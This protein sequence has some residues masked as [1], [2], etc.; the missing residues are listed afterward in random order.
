M[1]GELESTARTALAETGEEEWLGL[2]CGD[3]TPSGTSLSSAASP[4]DRGPSVGP[5]MPVQLFNLYYCSTS[6]TSCT[7]ACHWDH[8]TAAIGT[9]SS[10]S[11]V[12]R[13]CQWPGSGVL[14]SRR[15]GAQP[16]RA[17]AA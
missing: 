6:S 9:S 3:T 17:V 13:K 11:K 2:D 15:L 10:E 8:T 4:W 7:S 16:G 5:G 14:K 12:P 1:S